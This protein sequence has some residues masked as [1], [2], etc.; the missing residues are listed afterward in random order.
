MLDLLGLLQLLFRSHLT[1]SR[2]KGNE[3]RLLVLAEGGCLLL[4][5]L[6][7]LGLVLAEEIGLVGLRVEPM[8]I[9]LFTT[10]KCTWDVLIE[11][12]GSHRSHRSCSD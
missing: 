4:L 10:S 7:A 12:S 5:Q 6:L 1:V 3:L 8:H 2:L 11:F 9:M